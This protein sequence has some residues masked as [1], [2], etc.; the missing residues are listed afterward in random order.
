M[1]SNPFL[2]FAFFGTQKHNPGL[3]K[4][5]LFNI[6]LASDAAEKQIQKEFGTSEE[7]VGELEPRL[8]TSSLF[9][10]IA[11]DTVEEQTRRMLYSQMSSL[12]GR[13]IVFLVMY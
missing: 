1:D 7:D 10:A 12:R 6:K 4:Q 8:Q 5:A 9:I 11:F 3:D 13:F 2:V